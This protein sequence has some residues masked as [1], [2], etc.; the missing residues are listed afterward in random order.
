MPHV[1]VACEESQAV[2]ME[3]RKLGIKAYSCDL[4]ECSGN[5]PEWHILGDCIP[6]LNGYCSFKTQDGETHYIGKRWD[7]IIAFPP[8]THL[9]VSGARWFEQKRLDGRQK[10]AVDFFYKIVNADCDKISIENPVGI[11]SGVY[12]KEYYGIEP[13]KPKQIIQPWQ[14]GDHAIKTTCLWLKG[15]PELIPLVT[16]KPKFE[17]HTT[18]SGKRFEMFM[19]ETRCKSVKDGLRAKMASKTFPGIAK[20]MAEQWGK[21]I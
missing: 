19:Y 20:A 4:V 12:I 17:Y 6:L 5:N 14:Y 2:T 7:M 16:E 9:A 21:E 18:K 1:L 15:L 10:N 8:C 3:L 13:Y 11:I